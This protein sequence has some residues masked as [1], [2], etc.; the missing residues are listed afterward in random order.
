MAINNSPAILTALGVSGTVSTAVLAAKGG[1]QAARHMSD[2]DPYLSNKERVEETWQFFIPAAV[3]GATTIA[4]VILA[5]KAG[6]KKT[7]AIT[8]AYS[9]T[10]RAFMEYKDK[11]VDTLGEKKEK[12]IRD[13]IQQERVE[14]TPATNVLVAGS[15]D[16]RCYESYTGRYFESSI[17]SL[18]SAENE[19]NAKLNRELYVTLSDF[20]YILGLPSTTHSSAFGWEA[21]KL[22]HLEISTVL[23]PDGKP[24]LAFEYNYTTKL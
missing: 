9:L 16:V 8:A 22:M 15:G 5:A 19:V 2:K 4:C 21:G 1:Y 23:S 6:A 11:V 13:E 18:R 3:S 17:E 14:R 24:C 10:E 12:A 20:Y 7:A